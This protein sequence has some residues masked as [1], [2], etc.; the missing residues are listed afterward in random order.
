MAKAK[1]EVTPDEEVKKETTENEKAEH[2]KVTE[3]KTTAEEKK[4]ETKA[5]APSKLPDLK[6]VASMVTKL[7]VDIKT[8]VKEII[9]D[10]K[11]KRA[12]PDKKAANNEH[13]N[14][15]EKSA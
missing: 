15:N 6:E 5:E 3:E 2:D 12:V 8:S 4:A 9:T 1:Q 7:C 10:Y 11:A 14:N 13:E